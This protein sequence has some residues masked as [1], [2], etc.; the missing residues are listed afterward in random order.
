M[1]SP[2]VAIASVIEV[3]DGAVLV[4]EGLVEQAD[5]LV[6]LLQLALDDLLPDL[7]GLAL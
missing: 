1:F 5:L 7:G 2:I 6:P 3:P 4:A